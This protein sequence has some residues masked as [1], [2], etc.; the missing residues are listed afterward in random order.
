MFAKTNE[1]IFSY[2]NM[3]SRLYDI[4]F[5]NFTVKSSSCFL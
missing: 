5:V 2:I 3:E 1:I 4:V